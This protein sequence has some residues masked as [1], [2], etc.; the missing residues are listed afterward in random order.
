MEQL[1]NEFLLNHYHNVNEDNN[2]FMNLG[3]YDVTVYKSMIQ[4]IINGDTLNKTFTFQQIKITDNKSEHIIQ[5]AIEFPYYYS[6]NQSYEIL[7]MEKICKKK[8]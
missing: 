7:K 3:K 1:T 4:E 5:F 2:K 6:D 8:K